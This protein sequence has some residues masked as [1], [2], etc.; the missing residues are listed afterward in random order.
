MKTA[1]TIVVFNFFPKRKS[2]FARR[3]SVME[4]PLKPRG[5]RCASLSQRL[6]GMCEAHKGSRSKA[7][8]AVPLG[9]ASEPSGP[10]RHGAAGAGP[11]QDGA[12]NPGAPQWHQHRARNDP[13]TPALHTRRG[14]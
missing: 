12:A 9:A 11:G 14:L 5:A 2:E 7:G 10:A 4:K 6:S 3:G 1:K 8:E 13:V